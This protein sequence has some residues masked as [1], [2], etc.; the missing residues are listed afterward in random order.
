VYQTIRRAS[1]SLDEIFSI[2]DVEQHIADRPDAK[3]LAAISGEVVFENV[4][5][6]YE[7]IAPILRGIDFTAKPGET[8]AIVGPSGSGKSTLMSLLMRFY[9]PSHGAIRLDGTDLRELQ[10][11]SLRRQ[12]GVVLQE[13]L[14]FNDTVYNNI[15]YGRPEATM[16]EVVATA[17]AAN[18][19]DFIAALPEGYETIIGERGGR[20]SVGERQR[21]TIARALVKDP[22]LIVLDEATSSLDAESEGVVQDA[23]EK[24]M[25][26][27]TTFV[28]AHR[29]ATVVNASRILVLKEGRLAECGTHRELMAHGGYYASLVQRQ[30]RGLIS[31]GSAWT[32]VASEPAVAVVA[33]A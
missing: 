29:L 31:N 5:F 6:G 33:A 12:I 14:L 26:G 13:P 28:I 16:E 11:A 19:H 22:R 18:A 3:A 2:L 23:L 8:I 20:L 4:H 24:L 17:K 30:T 21:V 25:E 1:V 7:G 27:R 9:E 32:E 10:Q 15:A